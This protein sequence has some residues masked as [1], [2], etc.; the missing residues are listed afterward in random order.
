MITFAQKKLGPNET[1]AHRNGAGADSLLDAEA[2]RRAGMSY[3]WRKLGD[4]LGVDLPVWDGDVWNADLLLRD[5]AGVVGHL[6]FSRDGQVIVERSSTKQE[7]LEGLD[8]QR[9]ENKAA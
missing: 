3:C 5:H 7:I 2:V 4:A 8:A 1:Q 9:A 6:I